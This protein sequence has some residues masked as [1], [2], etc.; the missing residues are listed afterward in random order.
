MTIHKLVFTA[1]ALLISLSSFAVSVR[2]Q[3]IDV[4][5]ADGRIDVDAPLWLDLVNR[6]KLL[7]LKPGYLYIYCSKK[8]YFSIDQSRVIRVD[9]RTGP[10]QWQYTRIS[11]ANF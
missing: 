9:S 1:L 2:V 8:T 7:E 5:Q 4:G 11:L 6:T 10:I 3:I